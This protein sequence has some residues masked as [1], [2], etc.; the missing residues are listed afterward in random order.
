[1][2]IGP[3]AAMPYNIPVIHLYGG[4]VTLGAIDELIR[5]SITKMSHF[6]FTLLPIYKKRLIQLGEEKWRIEVAECMS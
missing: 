4:A 1:M 2:L 6:H 5:H 3:I